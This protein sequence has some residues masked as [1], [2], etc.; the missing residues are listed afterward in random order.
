MRSKILKFFLKFNV[1]ICLTILSG[2]MI[3]I[4]IDGTEWIENYFGFPK[5]TGLFL[6]S[7]S[8]FCTYYPISKIN[9][10]WYNFVDKAFRY[11]EDFLL[12]YP[13]IQVYKTYIVQLHE[14]DIYRVKNAIENAEK[15]L[16]KG[17][18][19]QCVHTMDWIQNELKD[20]IDD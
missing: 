11:F 14:Y 5:Y 10:L 13:I 20:F 17:K 2:F 15:Y 3:L 19:S 4:I 6:F 7:Y 18:I 9:L 16:M 1:T 8:L 12:L